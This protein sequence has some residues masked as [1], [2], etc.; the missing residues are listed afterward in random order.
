MDQENQKKVDE[1]W[2][3]QVNKEKKESV[4]SNDVYHQPTFSI[5]LSSLGMQAMIAMGKLE[6]PLTKKSE[7][8]FEQARFLIDTLGVIEQKTR[9]NLNPEEKTLLEEYLYNLRMMYIEL[10]KSTN[11]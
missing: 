2:K 6:N 4:D 5:F 7:T 3:N 9:N 10:K 8:N 11:D 1:N